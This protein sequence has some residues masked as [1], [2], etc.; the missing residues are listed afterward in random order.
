MKSKR[1]GARPGAGRKKGGTNGLT[2][3]S[4]LSTVQAKA[5]GQS[6]EEILVEDFLR[7]RDAGDGNLTQKYHHLILNKVAPTLAEIETTQGDEAVE[8]RQQAFA[9]ALKALATIGQTNAR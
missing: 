4:L 2:I 7:S 8:Q 6:Y 5:K 1:G 3:E 9:E